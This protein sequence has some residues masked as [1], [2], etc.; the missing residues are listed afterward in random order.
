M[1]MNVDRKPSRTSLEM[2]MW[3]LLWAG[4]CL[5]PGLLHAEEASTE[6]PA[7]AGIVA[8][9]LENGSRIQ[10]LTCTLT[11]QFISSDGPQ[12]EKAARLWLTRH[13]RRKEDCRAEDLPRVEIELATC[14]WQISGKDIRKTFWEGT[15]HF[16]PSPLITL[17]N[18][19]ELERATY[20]GLKEIGTFTCH[21]FDTPMFEWWYGEDGLLRRKVQKPLRGTQNETSFIQTFSDLQINPALDPGLFS[22]DLPEGAMV[23]EV[24]PDRK[25]PAEESS[26]IVPYVLPKGTPEAQALTVV[27]LDDVRAA[28]ARVTSFSCQ[29]QF[30]ETRHYQKV[31]PPP[32]TSTPTIPPDP[33]DTS[34]WKVPS[35]QQTGTLTWE[36][37]GRIAYRFAETSNVSPEKRDQF[38]LSDGETRWMTQPFGR[39]RAARAIPVIRENIAQKQQFLGEIEALA[40]KQQAIARRF[41][42]STRPVRVMPPSVLDSIGGGFDARLP[43]LLFEPFKKIATAALLFTGEERSGDEELLKFDVFENECNRKMFLWI[44]KQD[45]LPR[46]IQEFDWMGAKLEKEII[47]FDILINQPVAPE[48]FSL[49]PDSRYQIVDLGSG[50][51]GYAM[52]RKLLDMPPEDTFT[53]FFATPLGEVSELRGSGMGFMS[54]EYYIRFKCAGKVT[55]KDETGYIA[56]DARETAA[57]F[58]KL[59]PEDEKLLQ[60]P[61]ALSARK[62]EKSGKGSSSGAV[63]LVNPKEQVYFFRSWYAH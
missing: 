45:G 43:D 41:Q 26:R 24:F 22:I 49:E 57:Y 30:Q 19:K 7:H 56:V 6:T 1:A 15:V 46:R 60:P 48:T 16:I 39:A 37:T 33:G 21:V 50:G 14:S 54:G 25:G 23:T 44:G 51:G 18:R 36:K 62:T 31:G 29:Y 47:L 58:A 59:F 27:K 55:L 5:Y 3:L 32:G 61:E 10:A 8:T 40:Q 53:S 17:H 9:L 28:F 38:L 11:E 63:L 35:I 4:L 34:F 42:D 52:A 12:K 13:A 20:L 2:T